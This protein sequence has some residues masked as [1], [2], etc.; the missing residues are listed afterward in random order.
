ML[1]HDLLCN[2]GIYLAVH[3]LGLVA[4]HYLDD[5]FLFAQTN[6]A[7][8]RHRHTTDFSCFDESQD[9]L[10]CVARPG[11][12]SAR[13]HRNDY[14]DVAGCGFQLFL[15]QRFFAN[16]L[17]LIKRFNGRHMFLLCYAGTVCSAT[18]SIPSSIKPRRN[19]N[20]SGSVSEM[21]PSV[22]FNSALSN[23]KSR[24]VPLLSVIRYR[25]VQ[26]TCG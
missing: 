4:Q 12:N 24:L 11:S 20:T 25:N 17:E 6:A 26:S 10:H 16:A 8:L 14:L 2:L 5:G 9:T 1:F 15:L 21:S 23:R 18:S 22:F 3:N 7:R 13:S 19:L